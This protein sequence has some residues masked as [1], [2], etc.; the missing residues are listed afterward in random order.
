MS[1]ESFKNLHPSF[2]THIPSFS[3]TLVVGPVRMWPEWARLMTAP[4]QGLGSWLQPPPCNL[5]ASHTDPHL[6][7]WFSS[8][9][10]EPGSSK[11]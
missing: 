2:G 5:G 6:H 1:I 4:Q 9:F 11:V 3:Q 7:C 10:S 8:A